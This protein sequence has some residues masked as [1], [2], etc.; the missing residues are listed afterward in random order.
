[1]FLTPICHQRASCL[2]TS[3]EKIGLAWIELFSYVELDK[4]L[5]LMSTG[6]SLLICNAVE[7]LLEALTHVSHT[8]AHLLLR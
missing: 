3:S 4:Q 7:L 2:R 8:C 1:M 6:A 5:Y